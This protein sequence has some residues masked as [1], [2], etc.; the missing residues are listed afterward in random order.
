VQT[1]C[2]APN[3]RGGTWNKDG[4]IVFAPDTN[5]GLHRVSASGGSPTQISNPD[6]N[7]GEDGHR[8]PM[9]LPDGT[10]FLYLAA[11]FSG[12]KSV[13]AIFVGSLDSN[14]KRFVVDANANAAYAAPGYL[15]FYR[16]KTLLAQS[17]DRKRFAVTGDP[18]TVLT[19]IQ[20]LPQIRRVLFAVSNNGALVAQTGSAVALSQPV[21]FDRQCHGKSGEGKPSIKVPSLVS[22]DAKKMSDDE[23]REFI[24]T[25]A[26][27]E[28]DRNSS[29]TFLKKRLTEDQVN[30]I[31]A[32]IRKM[33]GR[34]P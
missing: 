33:Q 8:W 26:N 34:H 2:D 21:W 15:L 22:I 27:G 18:I 32:D 9:F 19:D 5:V 6:K 16:D 20:Y 31:I 23:I 28:M 17:F 4:V 10:H 3:G 11:N 12:R 30:Q 29:H 25:R 1:I 14:E 13:N 24:N 7:R